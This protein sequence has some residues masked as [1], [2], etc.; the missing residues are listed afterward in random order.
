MHRIVCLTFKVLLAA[1]VLYG[2]YPY[3]KMD[4]HKV[5]RVLNLVLG[6]S[7]LAGLLVIHHRGCVRSDHGVIFRFAVSVSE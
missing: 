7:I 3:Y 6:Q 2:W 1:M 4:V 5:S